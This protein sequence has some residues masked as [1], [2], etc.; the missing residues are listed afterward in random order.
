[1]SRSPL[2][3]PEDFRGPRLALRTQVRQ[4]VARGVVGGLVQDDPEQ[5]FQGDRQVAQGELLHL[6]GGIARSGNHGGTGEAGRPGD[7]INEPSFE[8]ATEA[9]SRVS[10]TTFVKGKV[11]AGPSP[12]P[13]TSTT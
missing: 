9:P 8:G 13:G 11:R 2:A 12:S 1:M 10:L 5:A 3:Q 7:T 4:G 6:Q